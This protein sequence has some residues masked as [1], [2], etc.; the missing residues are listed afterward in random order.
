[1]RSCEQ[2]VATMS[3]DGATSQTLRPSERYAGRLKEATDTLNLLRRV[4]R[5][6]LLRDSVQQAAAARMLARAFG[7]YADALRAIKAPAPVA[8]AHAQITAAAGRAHGAYRRMAEAV[9]TQDA[10]G[11]DA[12]VKDAYEAEVAIQRAF[13]ALRPLGYN[14]Q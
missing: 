10:A 5:I 3:L 2:V 7:R 9:A 1:M 4:G 8:R 12:S 6:R 14:V 11:Y 13:E